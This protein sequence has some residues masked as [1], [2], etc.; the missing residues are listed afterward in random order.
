M[1]KYNVK[2]YEMVKVSALR[3][4]I[5]RLRKSIDIFYAN[6]DEDHK[7][8]VNLAYNDIVRA[9]YRE[10]LKEAKSPEEIKAILEMPG[11]FLVI[12]VEG[13]KDISYFAE[14]IEKGKAGIT[15]DARQAMHFD[16]ESKAEE[17]AERLGEGWR[18][19]DNSSEDYEYHKR[20]LDAIF[21]E[22][23]E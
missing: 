7:A 13:K 23:N 16:Y 18:V 12:K 2:G 9:L 6:F 3:Y 8:M 10:E 19:F 1:K 22:D 20:L 4:E 5:R 21:G 14:W 17:I 15:K 11:D